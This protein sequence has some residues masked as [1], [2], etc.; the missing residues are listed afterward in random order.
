MSLAQ[1]QD[2]TKI[3]REEREAVGVGII[4][5]NIDEALTVAKAFAAS[6]LFPDAKTAGAALAKI[7]AGAEY[8][9]PPA[10]SMG[11]IHVVQGK[12][13]M[14]YALLGALI[15]RSGKY[16]YR[17]IEKTEVSCSIAFFENGQQVGT[18]TFTAADADRQGTQNMKKY[19]ATMLFARALAN[20]SRT[21]APEAFLGPVYIQEELS[22]QEPAAFAS[23][24]EALMA[25]LAANNPVA[26]PDTSEPE[27]YTPTQVVDAETGE[28][29]APEWTGARAVS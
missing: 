2:Q 7:L 11:C 17:V 10:Q 8:G 21:Y 26:E 6:G 15:K 29:Y 13:G 19:P 24:A 3:T 16:D 25:E 18:E 20:G 22:E 12:I 28:V 14:H 1:A 5:R 27:Q 9:I 4:P 23:K